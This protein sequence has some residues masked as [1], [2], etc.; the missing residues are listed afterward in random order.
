MLPCLVVYSIFIQVEHALYEWTNGHR[1]KAQFSDE[2][3]KLRY[4]NVLVEIPALTILNNKISN[5][6]E[7]VDNSRIEGTQMVQEIAGSTVHRGSV[8]DPLLFIHVTD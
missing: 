5:S 7:R 8:S 4:V 3:C 2:T 1:I 6:H